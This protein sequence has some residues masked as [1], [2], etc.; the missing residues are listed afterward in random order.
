MRYTHSAQLRSSLRPDLR[1]GQVYGNPSP[2]RNVD[3][4]LNS[5]HVSDWTLYTVK[6]A[7]TSPVVYSCIS[8]EIKSQL[9]SHISTDKCVETSPCLISFPSFCCVR[10][11]TC[12]F[13]LSSLR[14]TR[15]YGPPRQDGHRDRLAEAHCGVIKNA[16]AW[17]WI[18]CPTAAN[19]GAYAHGFF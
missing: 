12:F 1:Y 7:Q 18:A 17:R 6:C 8:T 5:D 14:G 9:T 16:E 13:I 15:S 19:S 2:S 3:I 11:S 10:R 4:R